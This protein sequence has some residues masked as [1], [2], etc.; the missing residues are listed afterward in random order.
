M[1]P[2]FSSV[3]PYMIKHTSKQIKHIKSGIFSLAQKVL[4]GNVRRLLAIG[5]TNPRNQ[6]YYTDLLHPSSLAQIQRTSP[7]SYVV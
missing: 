6:F 5:S 2:Y 7:D 3:L 4:G 1:I